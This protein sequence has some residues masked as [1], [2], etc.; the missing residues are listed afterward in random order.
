MRTPQAGKAL[1]MQVCGPAPTESQAR[2][3]TC[4]APPTERWEVEMRES[5]EFPWAGDPAYT[6]E[7]QVEGKDK[8]QG[9]LLTLC[10]HCGTGLERITGERNTKTEEWNDRNGLCL[11]ER[12]GG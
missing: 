9:C 2:E 6:V 12:R 7:K 1:G 5:P 4:D 10:V 8:T 3:H 11:W